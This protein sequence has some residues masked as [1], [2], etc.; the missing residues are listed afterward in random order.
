MFCSTILYKKG[1]GRKT[2]QRNDEDIRLHCSCTTDVN[3]CFYWW[4]YVTVNDNAVI[5][6][7]AIV[8]SGSH[9]L[10]K[11]I[12]LPTPTPGHLSVHLRLDPC[13]AQLNSN[14]QPSDDPSTR[15]LD[16]DNAF[17]MCVV[18]RRI[19]SYKEQ[20]R[21][22]EGCSKLKRS[23][24]MTSSGKNGLNITKNA[25]PKRDRTRCPEE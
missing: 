16:R 22:T 14:S 17:R 19:Y 18:I 9:G 21:S 7:M 23:V 3:I 4:F 10:K 11:K 8:C 13:M 6:V 20:N 25:S 5:I 1:Y 24:D 12:D 15:S 2:I